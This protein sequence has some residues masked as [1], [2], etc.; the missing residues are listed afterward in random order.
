MPSK[1]H[2]AVACMHRL[3]FRIVAR[4]GR[5]VCAKTRAHL[6]SSSSHRSGTRRVDP[7]M[8]LRA[9]TRPRMRSR[10]ASLGAEEK[11]AN[12]AEWLGLRRR[13]RTSGSVKLRKECLTVVARRGRREEEVLQG[14]THAPSRAVAAAVLRAY[15]MDG[16]VGK[17]LR[18]GTHRAGCRKA[19][20]MNSAS[21][22]GALEHQICSCRHSHMADWDRSFTHRTATSMPVAG[23]ARA[24]D[25]RAELERGGAHVTRFQ[26]Y[27]ALSCA[28]GRGIVVTSYHA[29][30]SKVRCW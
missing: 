5:G 2:R 14:L 26:S 30:Q 13:E 21:H 20:V 25:G 19:D 7:V 11:R 9:H 22:R 15:I 10:A 29:F 3:G 12:R 17:R 8:E 28:V 18:D 24:M 23:A 27:H 1:A 4:A 6:Y 16:L